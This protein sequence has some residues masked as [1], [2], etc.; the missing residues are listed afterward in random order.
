MTD[1]NL[2]DAANEIANEYGY[3]NINAAQSDLNNKMKSSDAIISSKAANTAGTMIAKLLQLVLYQEVVT[4]PENLSTGKQR[5]ISEAYEGNISHGNT[6]EES[7]LLPTGVENWDPNAYVPNERLEPKFTD[8]F[9]MSMYQTSGDLAAGAYRFKKRVSINVNEWLPYFKANTLNV[10]VEKYRKTIRD[11][12]DMYIADMLC[13][14]INTGTPQTIIND[15][16][17]GNTFECINTIGGIVENM[18]QENT[19][20]NYK[21]TLAIGYLTDNFSVYMNSK[22]IN[23]I[24]SGVASQLYHNN[25]VIGD[26][27]IFTKE[28]MRN[29][30]NKLVIPTTNDPITIN[31][32]S[33][34]VPENTIH[35][36]AK[37][38]L[39]HKNQVVYEE[40]QT[41]IN[42]MTVEVV[43]HVWGVVGIRPWA[44]WVKYTS[45]YLNTLPTG[46]NSNGNTGPITKA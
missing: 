25:F 5:V 44:Q 45:D 46:A 21:D 13:T 28:Q 1:K 40:Q 15:T 29:V 43:L 2:K 11:T 42:N 23:L 36:I 32:D 35:I 27:G 16:Q 20:Y 37:D 8:S 34:Y 18:K 24:N 9:V 19:E 12:Y 14:L 17:S 7:F 38:A 10:M 22:T 6:Y 33:P 4:L 41:Y 3:E 30:G 26:N 31:K 39:V